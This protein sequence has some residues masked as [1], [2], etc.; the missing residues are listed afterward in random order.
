MVVTKLEYQKNDPD[1]VNV[2]LDGEYKFS[3]F[4]SDIINFSIRI[5]AD[6]DQDKINE[7]IKSDFIERLYKRVIS[8]LSSSLKTKKQVEIYIHKTFLSKKDDW[9]KGIELQIDLEEVTNLVITKLEDLGLLSD[10]EF[11]D[12]YIRSYYLVKPVSLYEL[13]GKLMSKGVSKEIVEQA[14]Y[15]AKCDEKEMFKFALNKKFRTGSIPKND[16]KKIQYFARK[17]FSWDVI[18]EFVEE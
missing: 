9:L 16:Q 10:K 18:S 17:G 5:G 14:L 4:T 12:A 13:S 15:D 1:R 11:A 3:V 2:Y 7:I 8:L 6:L